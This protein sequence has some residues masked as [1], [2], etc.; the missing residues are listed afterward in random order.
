[1]SIK[2]KYWKEV[3]IETHVACSIYKLVQGV[4]L[5]VCSELFAIGNSIIF[6]ILHEFMYVVIVVYRTIIQGPRCLKM[7]ML[8]EKFKKMVWITLCFKAIDVTHIVTIKPLG[9]L[10]NDYYCF[11]I[12]KYS[13]VIAQVVVDYYKKS[14]ICLLVYLVLLMIIE[15]I[16]FLQMCTL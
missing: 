9:A 7:Q 1:M 13:I 8:I 2:T 16:V 4:N 14:Q 15:E 10:A 3:P 5:L 6:V 11:K 12:G